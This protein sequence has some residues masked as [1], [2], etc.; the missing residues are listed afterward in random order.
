MSQKGENAMLSCPSCNAPI[1]DNHDLGHCPG[2]DS[3]YCANCPSDMLVLDQATTY[4]FDGHHHLFVVFRCA[5]DGQLIEKP[6]G[7]AYIEA[8]RGLEKMKWPALA[9]Q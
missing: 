4:S 6:E 2:A 5:R 8:L 9:R 3:Y 1:S 7:A